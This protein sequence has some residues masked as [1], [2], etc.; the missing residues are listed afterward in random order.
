MVDMRWVQKPSRTLI[1][2]SFRVCPNIG[3]RLMRNSST[4]GARVVEK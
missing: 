3:V 2:A 4:M 1:G